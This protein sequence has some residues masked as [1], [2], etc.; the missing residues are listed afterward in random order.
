MSKVKDFYPLSP[1][2]AGMLFHS[3]MDPGSGV[4]VKQIT[5]ALSGE[6]DIPALDRAWRDVVD[7]YAILRTFFVWED[8][9]KPVQ[10]V[11]ASVDTAL[12][13]ERWSNLSAEELQ[14]RLEA[15]LHADRIRG[16]DMGQAPL[17]RM[18]LISLDDDNYRLIWTWHHI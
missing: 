11:Q 15:Y 7:R 18:T 5:Y 14:Q 17:M 1:M 12:H 3:L 10:V 4:Y 8:L 13:Q 2:Q 16:F 9:N 6:L